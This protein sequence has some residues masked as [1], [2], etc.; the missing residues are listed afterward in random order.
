MLRTTVAVIVTAVVVL[1]GARVMFPPG[2]ALGSGANQALDCR[3]V[4]V[5]TVPIT[6]ACIA[7]NV[8]V[9]CTPGPVAPVILISTGHQVLQFVL[10][11]TTSHTFNQSAGIKFTSSNARDY[12]PCAPDASDPLQQTYTCANN[13]NHL[14]AG[15]VDAYKYQIAVN[16][17]FTVDPW[18]VN[19]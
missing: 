15:T 16:W 3:T 6:F 13:L 17:M 11:K 12:Q 8:A 9:S 10:D 1:V 19:Y 4:P 7:S 5:C 2:E 14:P 18:A